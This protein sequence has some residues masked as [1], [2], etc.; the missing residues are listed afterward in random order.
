MHNFF[1]EKKADRKKEIR[2]SILKR[3]EKVK[4]YTLENNMDYAFEYFFNTVKA[5]FAEIFDINFQFTFEEL[6]YKLN[7]FDKSLQEINK[8]INSIKNKIKEKQKQSKKAKKDLKTAKKIIQNLN[9]ELNRE[10]EK[11]KEYIRLNTI[12]LNNNLKETIFSFSQRLSEVK[13]SQIP[14]SKEELTIFIRL[15]ENIVFYLTEPDNQIIEKGS[16]SMK[17]YFNELLNLL[18]TDNVSK[19]FKLLDLAKKELDK[20]NIKGA[21][22]YYLK[23]IKIYHN[24]PKEGVKEVYPEIA[25]FFNTMKKQ[26]QSS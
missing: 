26:K 9:S 14:I 19:V 8:R 5:A 13:Y 12:L 24:M 10:I 18:K 1:P 21:K 3:I 4:E 22:K 2:N 25:N 17:N 16:F 7:N 15:F 23:L 20:N 6:N 11:E